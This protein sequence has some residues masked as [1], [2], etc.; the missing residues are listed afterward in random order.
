MDAADH[1]P[2]IHTRLAARIGRQ[3]GQNP[4]KLR[5]AQPELIPNLTISSRKP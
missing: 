5:L 2:V 4:R 1:P 3:M